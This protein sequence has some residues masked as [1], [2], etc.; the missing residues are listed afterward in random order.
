MLPELALLEEINPIFVEVS[1][2]APPTTLSGRLPLTK[3]SVTVSPLSGWSI[4][5]C[6]LGLKYSNFSLVVYVLGG[7][8]INSEIKNNIRI[9]R[10]SRAP[11]HCTRWG[12]RVLYDNTNHTHTHMHARTHARAQDGHT[13]Q[14]FGI[15][16]FR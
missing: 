7:G 8:S 5:T 4:S 12:P 3:T 9:K 14:V 2:P 15:F 13:Q 6:T 11:V 16:S 10:I 1:S